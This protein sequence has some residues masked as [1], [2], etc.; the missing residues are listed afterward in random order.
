MGDPVVSKTT[1]ISAVRELAFWGCLSL[2][3]V[4]V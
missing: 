2:E 3:V 1:E 4:A